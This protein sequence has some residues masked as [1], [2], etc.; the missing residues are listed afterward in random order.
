MFH[1]ARSACQVVDFRPDCNRFA[2]H[3]VSLSWQVAIVGR[4][5]IAALATC[6]LSDWSSDAPEVA[7]C[8]DPGLA[9]DEASVTRDSQAA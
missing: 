1:A 3:G 9:G 8:G 5:T 2:G 4:L 7:L 6:L